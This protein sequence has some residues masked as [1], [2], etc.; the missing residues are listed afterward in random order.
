MKTVGSLDYGKLALQISASISPS[1]LSASFLRTPQM[2]F[3]DNYIIMVN[4]F[5]DLIL[6]SLDQA[7]KQFSLLEYKNIDAKGNV[8]V[9]P[10][11]E[12]GKVQV[13]YV[14]KQNMLTSVSIK[15][16][17]NS[18]SS[19]ETLFTSSQSKSVYLVSSQN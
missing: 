16:S 4:A 3:F 18:V 11:Y 9:K 19:S 8:I 17:H 10:S 2:L 6:A 5:N 14:S 1:E 15:I 12:P 13:I 7:T